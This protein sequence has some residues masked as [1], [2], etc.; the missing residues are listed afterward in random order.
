MV[1]P[2]FASTV[3]YPSAMTPRP[4][5]EE[6]TN[7]GLRLLT[8]RASA[9]DGLLVAF[10]DRDGGISRAPYDTLNLAARVGDERR[11]VDENRARVARAAGF[12]T[13]AIRLARQVHGAELIEVGWNDEVVAGQA[14]VVATTE[15]GVVIGILTADCTPVVVAGKGRVAVAHA[16][17]RGLVAG[18]VER[19]VAWVGE[20]ARA[21]VGPSIRS[22]CYQVGP[23]VIQAFEDRGLPVSAPD[24]V[25][26]PEAAMFVLDRAGVTEVAASGDCTS[27]D[28]RYF[29]YRRDGTTG[30]QGAFAALLAR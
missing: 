18:A 3:W 6:W 23:E 30:R 4:A 15:P 2:S 28:A 12:E 7:E 19:A 29:S 11:A 16:G 8:D 25:T 27:C 17:W 26:P 5:L 22:C 20:P 24:R 9:R 13:A 21:W 14:D 10:T 1:P